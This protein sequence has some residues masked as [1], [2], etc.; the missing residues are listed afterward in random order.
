MSQEELEEVTLVHVKLR[1]GN[2]LL[3]W[4]LSVAQSHRELRTVAGIIELS[5]L[6]V[7]GLEFC[8]PAPLPHQLVIGRRREC[9]TAGL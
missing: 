7:R 3:A 8:K 1:E 9:D 4:R 6:D 5:L 2:G